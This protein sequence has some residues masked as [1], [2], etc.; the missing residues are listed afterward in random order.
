MSFAASGWLLGLLLVPLAAAAY[1][2]SRRRA[3]RYAVRFTA[4]PALRAA[5]GTV[6]AWR[7]HLPAA[8]ALAALAALVLA[9]AKPQKTVAVA[10]ERASIM[11]VT[12]HSRSMSATDVEPNRLAAAQR[13]AR[14]FLDKLPSAV[15]V[16][17]VA[18]SDA[19]DAVQAPSTNHDDARRII[20]G[21]VADGATATGDALQVAIDALRNDKQKGKRPPSAIVLLSDG[22]T[23]TGPDPVP[24]ARAAGQLKIPVYT[25][26]LGSRDATVPNPNPF[27]TPLVVGPDPAT[28]REISRV[29]GGKAYT[30]EDSD[31]LNSI[32][33]SLGSQLGT[34]KKLKEV[35]ST[36]A[37]GGLILLLGAGLS[38]LR[39]AGRLP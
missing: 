36:F 9:M 26:A 5:A 37:I 22:K 21:Q 3:K 23:T 24:I 28:L 34:R 13:A 2:A 10:I 39:W 19:P 18:Y 14:A 33:K 16:G 1:A 30:A 4:V 27:G 32:Y 35:T 31:R 6:P 7:R 12:D 11:L 25:V 8:L 20:D 29:S 38:S 15:R 17:A